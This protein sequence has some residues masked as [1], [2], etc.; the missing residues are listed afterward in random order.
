LGKLQHDLGRVQRLFVYIK[1]VVP[2]VADILSSAASL[3][4]ILGGG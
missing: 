1:D 4:T 3:A 2:T